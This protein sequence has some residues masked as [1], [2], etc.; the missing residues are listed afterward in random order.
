MRPCWFVMLW[1]NPTSPGLETSLWTRASSVYYK[2]LLLM[3]LVHS[4]ESPGWAKP[5]AQIEVSEQWR[6]RSSR[7][8]IS[9]AA[10]WTEYFHLVTLWENRRKRKHNAA[11]R[12]DSMVCWTTDETLTLFFNLY[13]FW[14][15]SFCSFYFRSPPALQLAASPD[16]P[17][18]GHLFPNVGQQLSWWTAEK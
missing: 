6:R 2:A 17:W 15:N 7:R 14:R 18:T 9:L 10:E 11:F 4:S 5:L 8:W 3:G 16:F 13:S 1:P 12:V